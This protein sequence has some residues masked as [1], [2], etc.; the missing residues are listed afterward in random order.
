MGTTAKIL[1][2]DDEDRFR[3][4]ISR[5]LT[6]KGY[7]VDEAQN[8]VV[9]LEKLADG[10][11]DVVLLDMKMPQLSGEETFK[12]ILSQGFDVETVCLTGHVSAHD[13]MEMIRQGAFDY[14]LKP[15]SVSEILQKVQ[16]AVERKR[17]RNGEMDIN[18]LLR[19]PAE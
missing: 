7:E 17:V 1:V 5:I 6:D 13:A 14:L 4:T 3:K 11:F 2:V 19:S 18:D 10:G 12:S 16:Q 9:A 15:A 8:G